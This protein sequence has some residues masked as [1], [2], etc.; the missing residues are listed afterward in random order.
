[1][2]PSDEPTKKPELPPTRSLVSTWEAPWVNGYWWIMMPELL[3][4]ALVAIALAFAR[5]P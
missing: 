3:L 5:L 2:A 1:M 4:A